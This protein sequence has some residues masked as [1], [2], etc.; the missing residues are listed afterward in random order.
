MK[1]ILCLFLAITLTF[2][3][4]ACGDKQ[5]VSSDEAFVKPDSYSTVLL[6][7][8][9]PQFRLYLDD[10]DNVLAVEPVNEDAKT[11]I[12]D[13]QFNGGLDK[14]VEEIVNKTNAAGFVKENASVDFKII[15]TKKERT[16]ADNILNAAKDTANQAF[17]KIDITVEIKTSIS[18]NALNNST[19]QGTTSGNESNEI[20]TNSSETSTTHTHLFADAT[21]TLPKTC[22]CGETQGQALG[23]NFKNGKC[24]VC[25]ATDPNFTLTSLDKKN[26]NWVAEYVYNEIYCKV[27]LTLVGDA[28]VGVSVGDPLSKMEKELQDDIRNNKDQEGYKDSYVVY[29]GKEYWVARGSYSPLLPMVV[30]GNTIVLTS[31]DDNSAQVVLTR[32][33][34][35]TLT[36]KSCTQTFKDMMIYGIPT[37]TKLT[38]KAN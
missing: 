5:D 24:T 21:C 18:E 35:N 32:I 2:V 27:R 36:V 25:N 7:T 29:K 10:Q 16:Y 8:I 6:V 11:V 15:E 28:S 23:H 22:S 37:G 19:V 3:F 14:V 26:G 34:E 4:A 33:D 12:K 20:N 9:N 17:E 13:T 30:N 38:F 31:S 1:R